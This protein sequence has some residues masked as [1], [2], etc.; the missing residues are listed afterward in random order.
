MKKL[1][2]SILMCVAAMSAKAQ[3]TTSQT[4]NN[5]YEEL[6]SQ[7]KSDFAFNAEFTGKNLTTM[8]V[9]QKADDTLKPYMKYEYTYAADG[10]LTTKV[11][12]YW[13]DSQKEWSE[14]N[15]IDTPILFAK[16]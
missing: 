13:N 7:S 8:Y 16:K 14:M 6:I 4:V 12:Y 2:F 1:V 9:Y 3:V 11:T 10:T 5:V 15:V